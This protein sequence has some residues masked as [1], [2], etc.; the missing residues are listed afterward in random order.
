LEQ[1]ATIVNEACLTW[2]GEN[3]PEHEGGGYTYRAIA[4]CANYINKKLRALDGEK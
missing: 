1:E 2:F 3:P 4:D